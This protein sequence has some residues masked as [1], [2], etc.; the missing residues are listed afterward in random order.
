MTYGGV[1]FDFDY[2]LGDCTESI[3][4][5]FQK[6]FR[7]MGVPV[8]TEEEVRHT[9]GLTLQTA[10][11]RLTGDART[12]MGKKF[13]DLFQIYA[14][15]GMPEHTRFF[16]GTVELLTALHEADI[17]VAIVTTKRHDTLSRI[18]EYHGLD[19]L[20]PLI[21]GG[22]DVTRH[23]PDPQ[24]LCMALEQ[25]KLPPNRALFCG[26]TVIDAQTARGAGTEFAAVLNGTTSREAFAGYRAVHIS[27]DLPELQSWLG[28]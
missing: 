4:A 24:G 5:G 27:P 25:L 3:V 23:K 12:E 2:T 14:V 22:E 1:L 13:Y 21:V 28:L 10:Y 6:S 11:T 16:P 17:P 7:V 15:P 19:G 9:I 20:V 26:D 18:L 8:P